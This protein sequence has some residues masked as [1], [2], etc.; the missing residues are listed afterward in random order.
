MGRVYLAQDTSELDRMVAIKLLP[1]EVAADPKYM[2]RFIR[3]ARTVSALNHPNVLTIYEF[4]QFGATRFIATEFVDGVT[5]REYLRTQPMSL[6]D[7]VDI[8]MQI[9]A[10]L[11]AAH[12]AHV[13]HRDIKPDNIMVRRRDQIVKILDFGLAKPVKKNV[14]GQTG[15]PESG[16]SAL[17][18]EPGTVMG[19]LN[20]MSPEQAVGAGSLDYRTDIWSLGVVLYEMITG[21]V[22][23]QGKDLLEQVRAI[24]D[25]PHPPLSNFIEKLPQEF[26][27]IVAK[28]LAKDPDRRYQTTNE[29]LNDLKELKRT[30]DVDLRDDQR[31]ALFASM[32]RPTLGDEIVARGSTA[33]S[34]RASAAYPVSSA[35][36]IVNQIKLHKRFALLFLMVFVL[37][38]A[39]SLF[40]YL[41]HRGKAVLTDKDTILLAEIENKTGED[42]FEDTL[43]HGLAVQLQQSPFLDIFSDLRVRATL[44]L[45][46]LS[47][48]ERVTRERA[49]EIC[50][51]QGLKAFITGAIVKFDR[52]YSITL[53][54]LHGQTGEALALVQVEA[55]GKD[56]VLKAL[57]RGATELRE[58]LGESLSSIQKFDAKL[59]VTTSSLEALQQYALGRTE[60]DRGQSFKAIEFYRHA[61]EIDPNFATA[62]L[63]LGLQYANTSQPGLGAESLAKAF[64]L[65]DRVSENERARI[66]YF[67]YQIV[68]G[69]LEKAIEAQEAYTNSYPREARGPGNLGNLYSITGQFEKAVASTSAALQINPN[70]TIWPGNLAEALIAL[71]RWDQAQDVCDRALAQK[72]DS[73]SIR[74]R[75]FAVAF[76]KGDNQR[77]QDQLAWANGRQDEYRA[78][79]WQTQTSSFAGQWHKSEEQLSRAIELANRTGAKEVAASYTADQ[80]V[81]A[82]WL[83][84]SAQAVKLADDAL[85]IEHNRNVL[86][87]AALAFALAGQAGRAQSLVSELV[88]QYPKDTLVNQLWVPVIKAALELKTGDAETALASLEPAKRFE[89]VGGF[90]PQTLR[91]MAYLRSGQPD[92]AATE[93]RKIL[94][95][96]GQGPLSLLWPLAH[97]TLAQ[98]A[99]QKNDTTQARKSYEEFF[100]LWKAADSDLPVLIEAKQHFETLK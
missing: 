98:A 62:W 60:Q 6:H 4:G 69:E 37:G 73:T 34:S 94:D 8:A 75:L 77:M 21:R 45:M 99:A 72:L 27:D 43:R 5:L 49:R 71:N 80:A 12:E 61:T 47:P 78:I 1:A 13:V 55:E 19:T 54:A 65:K 81:R 57:S 85:K 44:Q 67:Y 66:T 16:T 23:F 89:G 100:A 18:T 58:K 9:A 48:D 38:S 32:M 51:R 14:E 96:R 64:A 52:N 56:Q 24:Q 87:S 25:Q 31:T 90:W 20:Y 33:A 26:E 3:E 84:H 15:N 22:P 2:Q 68:T 70:T 36:Y 79:Y 97:V 28:M 82:A 39:V 88:E 91:S 95:K 86:K 83:G 35:E 74:E 10:A 30:I 40:Y 41:S 42:V 59:E 50:Q 46:S 53:E 11:N 7:V 63:G 29:L 92:Q 17:H 93:A 76:V